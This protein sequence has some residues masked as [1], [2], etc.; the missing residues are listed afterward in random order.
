MKLFN[1]VFF[2]IEVFLPVPSQEGRRSCIKGIHF[3]SVSVLILLNFKI[4]LTV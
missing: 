3:A 1:P 4:V 2:F